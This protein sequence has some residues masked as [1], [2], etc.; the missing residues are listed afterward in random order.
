VKPLSNGDCIVA[1]RHDGHKRIVVE[2]ADPLEVADDSTFAYLG[3][4][5]RV[6][7]PAAL[8]A[9]LHSATLTEAAMTLKFIGNQMRLLGAVGP[10]GGW[11]DAFVDGVKEPTIVEFWNPSI[12]ITRAALSTCGRPKSKFLSVGRER[13]VKGILQI[14]NASI[15]PD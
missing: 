9:S 1:I 6:A 15:L 11:A 8:G 2:G 10:D 7:E 3:P 13:V 5:T 14:L 4:R 12:R